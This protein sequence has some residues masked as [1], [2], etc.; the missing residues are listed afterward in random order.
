[1]L[2]PL[3]SGL[4]QNVIMQS[5][6]AVA[7]YASLER[8]EADLRARYMNQHDLIQ[9]NWISIKIFEFGPWFELGNRK[10]SS[11]PQR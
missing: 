7:L 6:T 1:M 9:S 3:A 4:Y 2:S 8:D 10:K 5:G 11:S